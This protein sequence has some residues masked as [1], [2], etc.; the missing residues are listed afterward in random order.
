MMHQDGLLEKLEY[1]GFPGCMWALFSV[2]LGKI[3]PH[4]LISSN[5][6]SVWDLRKVGSQQLNW[7]FFV[8]KW[9]NIFYQHL[10]YLISE[11]L[12]KGVA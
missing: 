1:S 9:C 3:S 2:G 4:S 7:F 11:D 5:N 8:T 6:L 10:K 12:G